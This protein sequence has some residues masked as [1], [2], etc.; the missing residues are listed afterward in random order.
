[1]TSHSNGR[2]AAGFTLLEM[3]VAIAVMG[4]VLAMVARYGR[5]HSG[6][7]EMRAASGRVAAAMRLARGLAIAGGRAVVFVPPR[8]PGG[9][10]A[11]MQAGPGGIVFEPDGS[12]L[13]GRVVLAG[14]GR[15]AVIAA[16]W[17][18]GRISVG[19]R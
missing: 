2:G 19:T 9:V 1:M 6:R 13:G 7:L 18:T 11:V 5:P 8:L 3:I 4:L 14:A 10:R 17:L 15:K 12:A 16:D